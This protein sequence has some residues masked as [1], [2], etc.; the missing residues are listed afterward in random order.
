MRLFAQT[1]EIERQIQTRLW[2]QRL[3]ESFGVAG[4]PPA[5]VLLTL[6]AILASAVAAIWL[7]RARRRGAG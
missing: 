5:A 2:Y 3:Y 6:A 4:L 1:A 7:W